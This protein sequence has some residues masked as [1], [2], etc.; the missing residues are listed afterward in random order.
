MRLFLNLLHV[1]PRPSLEAYLVNAGRIHHRD[2]HQKEVG[3]VV[4]G[5]IQVTLAMNNNVGEHYSQQSGIQGI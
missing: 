4:G 2:L 1:E 5:E 3:W